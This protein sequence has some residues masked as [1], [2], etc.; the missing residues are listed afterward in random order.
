MI[1]NA[2]LRT[3]NTLYIHFFILQKQ[4]VAQNKKETLTTKLTGV[5]VTAQQITYSTGHGNS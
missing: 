5:N 1:K 2:R 4:T 3:G